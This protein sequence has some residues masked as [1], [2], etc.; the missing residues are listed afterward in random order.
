MKRILIGLAIINLSI[1]IG[2]LPL[3][4]MYYSDAVGTLLQTYDRLGENGTYSDEEGS[5]FKQIEQASFDLSVAILVV[6]SLQAMA[7]VTAGVLLKRPLQ[8]VPKDKG[9]L[10]MLP[11]SIISLLL[12]MNILLFYPVVPAV[13]HVYSSVHWQAT[14]ET[15]GRMNDGGSFTEAESAAYRAVSLPPWLGLL[16]LAQATVVA[17]ICCE[18]NVRYR[19]ARQR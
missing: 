9:E 12:V 16:Y 8:L 19:L 15:Y 5:L 10:Q 17:W 18:I 3:C 1:A 11:L 4:L 7:F 14:V 13:A 2:C 6:H